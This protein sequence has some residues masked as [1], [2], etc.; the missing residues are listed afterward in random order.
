MPKRHHGRD[1]AIIDPR[2][3]II[4]TH[5]HLFHRPNMRYLL[6]DFLAD[7][8]AGHLD[9]TVGRQPRRAFIAQDAQTRLPNGAAR[10]LGARLGRSAALCGRLVAH[11]LI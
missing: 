3:P 4:D 10:S 8:D 7:A 11:A 6:D 5:H 2:L 1:E 9:D